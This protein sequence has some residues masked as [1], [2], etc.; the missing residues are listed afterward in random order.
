MGVSLLEGLLLKSFIT[1]VVLATVA[2]LVL[3][4]KPQVTKKIKSK[5]IKD[6]E[7]VEDEG[8]EDGGDGEGKRKHGEGKD[9][10]DGEAIVGGADERDELKEKP[11]DVDMELQSLGSEARIDIPEDPKHPKDPKDKEK[12]YFAGV[13]PGAVMA[14]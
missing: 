4:C 3:C 8:D 6:G 10:E 12:D 13:L 1:A 9:G 2:S 7:D 14:A 11:Q 5:W